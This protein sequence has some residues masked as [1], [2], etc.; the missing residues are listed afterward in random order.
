MTVR[1][2]ASLVKNG[3]RTELAVP[4]ESLGL[5][6]MFTR[7]DTPR[8]PERAM[9]SCLIGVQVWPVRVRKLMAVIH[10]SV[11]RLLR[12]RIVIFQRKLH[13]PLPTWS[14]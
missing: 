9:N 3:P 8:T 1:S 6:S 11:V 5:F 4:P 2:G 7:A 12:V 14:L 13:S 10:S